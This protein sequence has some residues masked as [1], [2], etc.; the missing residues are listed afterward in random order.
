MLLGTADLL[1]FTSKLLEGGTSLEGQCLQTLCDR[2]AAI[3]LLREALQSRHNLRDLAD[4]L[5]SILERSS[6]GLSH[7]GRGECM[8]RMGRFGSGISDLGG[9]DTIKV[10]HVI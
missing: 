10:C 2:L 4:Q 3:C 6:R 7:T 9:L 1:L 8:G 5:D